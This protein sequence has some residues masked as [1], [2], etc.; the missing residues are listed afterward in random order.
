MKNRFLIFW[1]LISTFCMSLV[2]SGIIFGY[3]DWRPADYGNIQTS[4]VVYSIY[5]I[6]L[7]S[8][9]GAALFCKFGDKGFVYKWF[10]ITSITGFFVM[11]LHDFIILHIM[12]V[13]TRGQ[14]VLILILSLPIL[15][16][17]GGFILGFTQLWIIKN[18]YKP[19]L[20]F[21]SLNNQWLSIGVVSWI[22][23]FAGMFFGSF[24]PA[25]L[26]LYPVGSIIKGWFIN[27]YL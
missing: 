27:K 11:F 22:I 24:Y 2:V 26:I 13:D 6:L 17:V 25:L 19:N 14:G 1:T 21:I 9:Q 10:L 12:N 3:I 8:L 7:T 23:G 16:I 18:S 15:A 5:W 4:I 20:E